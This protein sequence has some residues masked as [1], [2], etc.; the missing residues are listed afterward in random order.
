MVPKNDGSWQP[1]GDYRHLNMITT[2]DKYPLPNMQD[3]SNGLDGCSVFSKVDLVKGYH[4][5]PVAPK[6]IPRTASSPPLVCLS[7][8]SP[9]FGLSN[10]AQTF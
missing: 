9:L 1:C 7:I 4:Q 6:D 8:Y 10:A 3:L 5:I 2:P